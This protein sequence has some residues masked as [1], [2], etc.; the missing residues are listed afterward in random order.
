MSQAG[1]RER[2]LALVQELAG[3]GVRMEPGMRIADAG[4]D[5]L[6]FAELAAAL[7]RD[8][9]VDLS[10]EPVDGTHRIEDVL[11]AV[12]TAPTSAG[13]TALPRGIGSLQ[14]TAR[15]LGGWALRWRFR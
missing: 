6:A 5:S 7:E 14:E 10:L 11:R 15:L 8:L 4:L 9:G 3:A 2:A 12:E 13:P 1:R